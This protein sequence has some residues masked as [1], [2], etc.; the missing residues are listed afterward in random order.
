MYQSG[1]YETVNMILQNPALWDKGMI[2]K[3]LRRYKKSN[4]YT[5]RNFNPLDVQELIKNYL[6]A[7]S[8]V[9]KQERADKKM[10]LDV[11]SLSDF[12]LPEWVW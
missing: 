3:T 2:K 6:H 1:N 12:T 10:R 8:D 7:L 5:E 4:S 11:R 9:M